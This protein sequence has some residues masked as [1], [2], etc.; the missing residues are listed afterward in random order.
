M[1]RDQALSKIKKCLAL[2]RSANPSEAG[3]AMRQ[4]QK[5]M[6]E[7]RVTEHD[8]SLL[9]VGE[10]GA[11]AS[12]AAFNVWETRLA[13]MVADAFG[14]SY[15]GRSG[16][17]ITATGSW[18]REL[19]YFFVGL[20]GAADVAAYA[21]EVLSRQ[22]AKA[23]LVHIQKQPKNCKPI[24]KSARGDEFARGWVW[25]VSALVEKFSSPESNKQ[26]LVTYLAQK[27]PNLG[28]AKPRDTTKDR[29]LDVGHTMAGY[30]AGQK[31]ELNRGVGAMRQEL[32]A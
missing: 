25:A 18:V 31:A 6:A 16:G 15:Y 22:C 17:R 7:H 24:T 26:L 3:I 11:K 4:A 32:L 9:D 8:L 10:V 12:T 1:N 5:L 21:F 29:K 14:C 13:S 2:A 23:R 19:K 30:A 28:P 20:N 27:H